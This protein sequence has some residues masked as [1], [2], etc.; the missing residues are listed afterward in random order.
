MRQSKA[1]FIV[2]FV[3]FSTNLIFALT[4]NAEI[5]PKGTEFRASLISS[6]QWSDR[7]HG[8]GFSLRLTDNPIKINRR[9][10]IPL[11]SVF[12]GEIVK[13]VRTA[14][15][16]YTLILKINQV[17]LPDGNKYP[18]TASL[19]MSAGG[20]QHSNEELKRVIHP[21]G[22]PIGNLA[23]SN[24]DDEFI[25]LNRIKRELE[26]P[27]GTV[28]ILNVGRDVDISHREGKFPKHHVSTESDLSTV[29]LRNGKVIFCKILDFSRNTHRFTI[30]HDGETKDYSPDD[31]HMINFQDNRINIPEDLVKIRPKLDTFILKNGEVIHGTIIDLSS[32]TMIFEIKLRSETRNINMNEIA[33][34]YLR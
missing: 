25:I 19:A 8:S 4:V 33:R 2:L 18:F 30:N 26:L 3:L 13:M 5:L 23:V 22:S 10:V 17:S 12:D 1:I 11:D 21:D 9:I 15:N 28:F 7:Y 32:Q 20:K 34:I 16:I 31:I 6:I 27:A 14:N 24:K 29:Q